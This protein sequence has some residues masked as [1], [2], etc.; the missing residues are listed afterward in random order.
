VDLFRKEKR[1]RPQGYSSKQKQRYQWWPTKLKQRRRRQLVRQGESFE[2]DRRVE[3]SDI[4]N[5]AADPA[6]AE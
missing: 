5:V 3:V 4:I 2:L 1:Q 6:E